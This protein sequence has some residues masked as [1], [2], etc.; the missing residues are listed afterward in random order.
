M[1]VIK[2]FYDKFGAFF[3][4][5]WHQ[6][7]GEA[8]QETHAQKRRGKNVIVSAGQ[9]KEKRESGRTGPS[10]LLPRQKEEEFRSQL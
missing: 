5:I 9:Q 7:F 6:F 4:T 1:R 10:S 8:R 3:R 2:L